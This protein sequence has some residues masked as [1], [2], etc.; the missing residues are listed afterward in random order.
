MR[1]LDAATLDQPEVR[2]SLVIRDSATALKV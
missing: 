1:G 2:P